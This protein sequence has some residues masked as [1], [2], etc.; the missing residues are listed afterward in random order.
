MTDLLLAEPLPLPEL[1]EAHW[2]GSL[3]APALQLQAIMAQ[4]RSIRRLQD[5]PF[6]AAIRGRLREAVRLTPAAYNLPPWRV[7]LVHERRE[8]L[9]AEIELGFAESL[10][11]DRLARYRE[12]LQGF[13]PGVAVALI[14]VDRKVEQ[15]L[16]E[17]KGASPDVAQGFVLQA[18]GMVQLSLWLA[19]TAEGLATSLQHWDEWI[20]ERAARFAGL[21]EEEFALV[22][23][24]PIG[25]PDE[26]PKVIERAAPEQ[27]CTVD[28]AG[29]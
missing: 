23:T 27:I 11:G 24:L 17:E 2:D 28:P 9:W 1:D 3:A 21:P 19:I 29:E 16:R 15:A 18:L 12:R 10:S 13:R 26:E 8:A 5:G 20:G 7:V 6:S 14:F 25:Y 4:R 22:A